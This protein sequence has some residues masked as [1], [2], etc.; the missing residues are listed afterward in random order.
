MIR[1]VRYRSHPGDLP[2]P[3]VNSTNNSGPA[4]PLAQRHHITAMLTSMDWWVAFQGID[5]LMILNIVVGGW[6]T[7]YRL[8]FSL[9]KW[10]KDWTMQSTCCKVMLFNNTWVKSIL[11]VLLLCTFFFQSGMGEQRLEDMDTLAD[12]S[13][14]RLP[15]GHSLASYMRPMPPLQVV[16]KSSRFDVGCRPWRLLTISVSN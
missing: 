14:L 2:W 6:L 15:A 7:H 11:I 8:T 4:R 3:L 13:G 16:S 1:L 12:A 5:R 9:T 10:R